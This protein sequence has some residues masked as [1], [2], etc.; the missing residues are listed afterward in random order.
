MANPAD[1]NAAF[2]R[3]SLLV[4]MIIILI[5]VF[6]FTD[7]DTE[8]QRYIKKSLRRKMNDS[9]SSPEALFSGNVDYS[10]RSLYAHNP[11]AGLEM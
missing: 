4:V 2:L 8:V 3:N 10:N 6:Q 9:I 11:S 1:A 5:V 7:P